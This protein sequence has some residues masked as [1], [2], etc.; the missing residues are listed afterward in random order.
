MKK[1]NEINKIVL[2]YISSGTIVL[3]Y[4]RA[5]TIILVVLQLSGQRK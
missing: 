5:Y 1:K 3:E 4:N 2:E